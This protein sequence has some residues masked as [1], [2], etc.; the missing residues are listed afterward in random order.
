M[1]TIFPPPFCIVVVVDD[2]DVC[3][4]FVFVFVFVAY[5]Y[6]RESRVLVCTTDCVLFSLVIQ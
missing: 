3:L 2:D 1:D 4:F 6:N 5:L